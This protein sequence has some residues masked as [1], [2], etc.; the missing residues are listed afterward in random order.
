MFYITSKNKGK[1]KLW[2]ALICNKIF[3]VSK[4]SNTFYDL[5]INIPHELW[6]IGCVNIEPARI[7]KGF[8]MS[9]NVLL[10]FFNELGKSD[11]MPVSLNIL[12]L[13]RN[14]LNKLNNT[15]AQ[16]IYSIYHMKLKILQNRIF[17]VQIEDFLS[18]TQL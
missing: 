1:T 15:G 10:N 3:V 13:F 18:F 16:K 2:K 5:V 4:C 12:S 11:K 8:Y 6:I 7:N 14:E 17:G 9:A